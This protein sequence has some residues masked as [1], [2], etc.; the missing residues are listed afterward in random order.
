[1]LR[2]YGV[3]T[4]LVGFRVVLSSIQLVC[5]CVNAWAQVCHAYLG[6]SPKRSD[7][8][9]VHGNISANRSA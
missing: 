7:I 8:Y 2:K 9:N 3:A 5:V 1:M 4:Q 6:A